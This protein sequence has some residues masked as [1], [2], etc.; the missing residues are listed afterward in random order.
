MMTM[1]IGMTMM[2]I[3]IRIESYLKS[4]TALRR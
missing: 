3:E 4:A 1:K 2:M